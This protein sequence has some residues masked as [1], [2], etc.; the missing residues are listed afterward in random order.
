MNNKKDKLQRRYPNAI[1]PAPFAQMFDINFIKLEEGI[2]HSEVIVDKAWTNPFSYFVLLINLLA[3][4][5]VLS[6]VS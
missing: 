1:F 5:L 2:A 6:T 4:S 3:V